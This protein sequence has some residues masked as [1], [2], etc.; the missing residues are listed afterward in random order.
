[1]RGPCLLIVQFPRLA[2]VSFQLLI[3]KK[4]GLTPASLG[5]QQEQMMLAT[6]AEVDR[7]LA[8]LRDSA[9]ED[10]FWRCNVKRA[11]HC[12]HMLQAHA[13]PSHL[14]REW[15]PRGPHP[16]GHGHQRESHCQTEGDQYAFSRALE[17]MN[18]V[19]RMV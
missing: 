15:P 7:A 17:A 10:Q 6:R 5:T 8:E 2:L 3:A 14:R 19:G 9:R 13:E 18:Q 16:G 4:Y 1:M 12:A 11:G